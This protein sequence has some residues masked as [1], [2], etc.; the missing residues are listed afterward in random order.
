MIAAKREAITT[1]LNPT[2]NPNMF[3]TCPIICGPTKY[4]ARPIVIIALILSAE[5]PYSLL[6]ARLNSI[7]V[8]FA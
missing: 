3:D 2:V 1:Q 8:R 4:P 5:F 6:P 7:G